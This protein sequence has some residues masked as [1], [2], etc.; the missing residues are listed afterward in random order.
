MMQRGGR[1][2][3]CRFAG[4]A[5]KQSTKNSQQKTV[6]GKQPFVLPMLEKPDLQDDKIIACLRDNYGLAVV[7]VSFLPLGAD[8]N[9]AVYRAVTNDAVPYFVKLRRGAFDETSVTLPKF[10]SEQG[11][12]HIIAPLATQTGQLWGYVDGFK[13]I[14]YPFVAGRDG[15]E[16]G[17]SD[18]QWPELGATLKRFHTTELPATLTGRIRR[19]TYSPGWRERVREFLN[20]A[21]HELFDDPVANELA[22]FL[23][24]KRDE[25]LELVARAERLGQTLQAGSAEMI[26]CHSDLHAG[27]ILVEGNGRFY[28]VDWDDPILAPKER[29]LMFIGGG[30][31]GNWRTPEEEEA[32]FYRGYGHTQIDATA[33]AYYRCERIIQDIAVYCEELLLTAEGG[34]DRAQ[35]L[36]YLK[37]NFLPGSTIEIARETG[38]SGGM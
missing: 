13:V 31:L 35:S 30:L 4:K 20:R 36:R 33:L 1:F 10:L 7:Q 24:V 22:A 27:N 37:S 32:L 8:G 25:I 12:A 11:I 3:R 19:E 23:R 21:Q 5:K 38:V 18:Q 34:A 17:L 16:V 14:L 29:D 28:I 6:N 26:V 15:Y 9:T 2:I